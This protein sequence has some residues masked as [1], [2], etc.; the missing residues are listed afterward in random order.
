MIVIG[1]VVLILA[2]VLTVGIVL[3]NSADARAEA[4]GVSLDNVSVGGLFLVGVITGA[5]GLL[6]L[7]MALGGL[8][9]RRRQR[10]ATRH[11]VTSAR[12]QADTLAEENARLQEQLTRERTAGTSD[13]YAG[14]PPGR[15]AASA[16][17]AGTSPGHGDRSGRHSG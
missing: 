9:R 11:A 6:G 7:V 15:D 12:S 5:L 8:A 2:T 17:D 4:F 10:A 14:D 1:L 16:H 13:P 3:P